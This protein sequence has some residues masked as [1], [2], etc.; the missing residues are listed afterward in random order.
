VD[1]TDRLGDD[2]VVEYR[3]DLKNQLS[4]SGWGTAARN[5]FWAFLLFRVLAGLLVISLLIWLF[6]KFWEKVSAAIT[7]ETSTSFGYGL[8]YLFFVPL[9]A[10]VAIMLVIGIPVGLILL[11]VYGISLAVGHSVASVT[12]AYLLQRRQGEGWSK[13]K[14]ILVAFV[15]FCLI[16]VATWL[17]ILGWLISLLL[18]AF[19]L[20]GIL[21]VWR[22]NRR[23]VQTELV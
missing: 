18:I 5:G 14:L 13:G 4:E 10:I 9:I 7:G 2:A 19:A 22:Q 8:L 20:G 3:E 12:G 15:I 17:P 21:L 16:K 23:Q 11:A 6:P 1:F